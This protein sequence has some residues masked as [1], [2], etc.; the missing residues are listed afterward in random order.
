MA[1]E[2]A[3]KELITLK[4]I[5]GKKSV[6]NVKAS[7][8]D[9]QMLHIVQYYPSENLEQRVQRMNGISQN[10]IE[11]MMRQ[12]MECLD[13][14]HN[15]GIIHSNLSTRSIIYKYSDQDEIYLSDFSDSINVASITGNK[16][17]LQAISNSIF[18]SPEIISSQSI[19]KDQ[20]SKIDVWSLGV[21][22]YFCV[23]KDY[24]F[25]SMQEI[26]QKDSSQ[27]TIVNENRKLIDLILSCLHRDHLK[28]PF[29]SDLSNKL[30]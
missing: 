8:T 28:R 22:L 18:S 16:I 20:L 15:H 2:K 10:K 30:K 24:P 9:N 25:K 5:G 13:F 19:S 26:I 1:F 3:K 21:I 7:F 11:L 14:I 29:V 17:N 6:V 12:M 4:S 27:L 23:N